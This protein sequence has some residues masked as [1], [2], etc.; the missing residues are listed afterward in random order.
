MEFGLLSRMTA[1]LSKHQKAMANEEREHTEL[2]TT[3]EAQAA[4]IQLQIVE[5]HKLH[6]IR[7]AANEELLGEL[8]IKVDQLTPAAPQA[9]ATEAKT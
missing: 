8:Q 5:A 6:S 3:L 2:V 4:E 1:I 9:K 7:T